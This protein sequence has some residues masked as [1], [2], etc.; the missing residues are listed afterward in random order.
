M[1]IAVVRQEVTQWPL[2]LTLDDQHSMAGQKL[3]GF[4]A[5][6]IEV[7]ISEN[8]Q[9][10]RDNSLAWGVINSAPVGSPDPVVVVPETVD[11]R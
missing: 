2:T 7:Q 5:V 10:G 9:P 8:G 6:S 3:S 4:N 11:I 1:P